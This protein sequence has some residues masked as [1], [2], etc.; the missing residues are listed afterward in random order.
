MDKV[1]IKIKTT[2]K[3]YLREKNSFVMGGNSY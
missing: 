3:E 1:G 2:R